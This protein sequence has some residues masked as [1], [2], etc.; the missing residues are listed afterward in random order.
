MLVATV[1]GKPY[2]KIISVLKSLGLPFDSASP[3][4]AAL[5]NSELVITTER[6]MMA[7]GNKNMILDSELD[8]EPALVRAKILRSVQGTYH[9]D[10]LLIGIDPGS[11]IGIAVFYLQKEIDSQVVTSVRKSI[12]LVSTLIRGTESRKKI[13]RIGYGDPLMASEIANELYEKFRDSIAIEF[14]NEHGTSAVHSA[15]VNRRGMRDRLS[16]RTIALR[17]GKP[18]RPLISVRK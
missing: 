15:D 5:I 11:R 13:V 6:E 17:R 12:D 3:E 4:E 8:D 14:V 7:V 10:Q 16:A 18:F 1:Y 2:Y 9:D